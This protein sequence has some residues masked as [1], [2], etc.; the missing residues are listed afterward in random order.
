MLSAYANIEVP[1]TESGKNCNIGRRVDFDSE[2]NHI[3]WVFEHYRRGYPSLDP[4]ALLA[5]VIA[6]LQSL[7]TS[8]QVHFALATLPGTGESTADYLPQIACPTLF[9]NSKSRLYETTKRAHS[10]VAGAAYLEIE[11]GNTFLPNEPEAF[12]RAILEFLVPL[13]DPAEIA[14]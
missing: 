14:S 9:V 8:W 5:E 1:T 3:K 4:D 2:G 12:G 7:Q 10:R 11:G 13:A 6:G